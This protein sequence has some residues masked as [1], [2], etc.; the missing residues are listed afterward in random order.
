MLK[1]NNSYKALWQISTGL[2]SLQMN[3]S[4]R[5]SEMCFLDMQGESAQITDLEAL[6]RAVRRGDFWLGREHDPLIHPI[7]RVLAANIFHSQT[8]KAYFVVGVV[9]F[10]DVHKLPSFSSKGIDVSYLT[11]AG[12]VSYVQGDA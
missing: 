8:S 9:G 10:Y 12:T 1:H 7:G 3:S 4:R 6:V 5:S 2:S 11:V